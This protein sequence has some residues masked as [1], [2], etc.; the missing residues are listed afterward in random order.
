MR[1]RKRKLE[2]LLSRLARHPS[3]R[4]RLE[5]YDLSPQGAAKVVTWAWDN[6][7]IEEKVI[8]DLGCGTGMLSIAAA[9]SGAR[10]V[11]GV[12]LDAKALEV[13]RENINIASRSC[14]RELSSVVELRQAD[15]ET[16]DAGALGDFD[17]VI[18]N[19]PFGVQLRSSDRIFLR[20]A[21]ELAPVVYSIHKRS[22]AVE[23]FI[24]GYVGGLGGTVE[25]KIPLDIVISHQF[26]FHRKPSYVVAADLF[27]IRRKEF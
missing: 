22:P 11:C 20:K 24:V 7:D 3:P 6:G 10:R 18:Q 1:L 4:A 25:G 9:L 19:P 12:D 17:T 16:I 5:Q 13:A 14:Q 26:P 8:C 23:R 27:R 15:V 2:M 21:L